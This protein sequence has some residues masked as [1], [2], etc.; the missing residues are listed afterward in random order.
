MV[1]CWLVGWLVV[2]NPIQ[3][4]LSCGRSQEKWYR[5]VQ[6]IELGMDRMIPSEVGTNESCGALLPFT[7]LAPRPC[8]SVL[9]QA[10]KCSAGRK[11]YF[12]RALG[13]EISVDTKAM[14]MGIYRVGGVGLVHVNV[15]KRGASASHSILYTKRNSKTIRK[16]KC[17]TQR[18]RWNSHPSKSFV[19]WVL[20]SIGNSPANK[21]QMP[22]A[23][24]IEKK[25]LMLFSFV[26]PN[27]EKTMDTTAYWK[28]MKVNI[29]LCR[30]GADA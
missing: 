22:G 16:Q 25:P 8:S 6:F 1:G 12:S 3:I 21:K 13:M 14:K 28:K 10:K 29:T 15:I 30:H 17:K 18:P 9:H 4:K 27:L 24:D 20:V 5:T 19:W 26:L 11:P 7:C 23:P 2:S